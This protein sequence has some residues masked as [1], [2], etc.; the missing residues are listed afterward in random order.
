MIGN[1]LCI[2]KGSGTHTAFKK[3]LATDGDTISCVPQ[4]DTST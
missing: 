1:I 3:L 2:L 4:N